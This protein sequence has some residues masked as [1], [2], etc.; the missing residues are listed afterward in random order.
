MKDLSLFI[1]LLIIVTLLVFRSDL[2]KEKQAVEDN[3]VSYHVETYEPF[4]KV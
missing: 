1:P 2:T 3:S 4:F